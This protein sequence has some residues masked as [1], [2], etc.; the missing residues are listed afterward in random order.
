MPVCCFTGSRPQNL[1]WRAES[2]PRCQNLLEQLEAE[3]RK[4][5]ADGFRH[6]ISGMAAGVDIFAAR[7]VLRL[8]AEQPAL[9]LTLEAAIPCPDQDKLWPDAQKKEYARL[10]SLCGERT[11]VS[12]KYSVCCFQKRNEYMVDQSSLVIA[13]TDGRPGGTMNTVNYARSKD[14]RVIVLK[15]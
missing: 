14:I 10:L 1:P 9:G 7:I 8:Q 4:A 12:E 15:P 5:V 6:F 3:I 13:V 2:D 11:L